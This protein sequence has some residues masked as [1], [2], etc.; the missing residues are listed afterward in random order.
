PT[1]NNT[2]DHFDFLNKAFNNGVD[3]IYVIA[4]Y[5]INPGLDIDPQSPTNVRG[6]L[7]SDFRAMV[8]THKNH[9]SILMWS[10]GSDL[11]ASSMYGSNLN[12]L[13]SLINDMAAE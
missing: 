10:I 5:W 13:F 9:P 6:Q 11:N 12:N 7:K 3:P 2:A 4:G 8:A 1:W